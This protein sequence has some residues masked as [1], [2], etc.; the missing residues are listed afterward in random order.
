MKF[1]I[2]KLPGVINLFWNKYVRKNAFRTEEHFLGGRLC[3]Q[4]NSSL[5]LH[6]PYSLYTY[7]QEESIWTNRNHSFF[8]FIHQFLIRIKI[9]S[10]TYRIVFILIHMHVPNNFRFEWKSEL[11]QTIKQFSIRM[12]IRAIVCYIVITY[13]TQI[14]VVRNQRTSSNQRASSM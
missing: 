1:R 2:L 12:K 7:H 10:G 6:V 13:I 9:H 5:P 11:N 4:G 3:P 8:I 14:C